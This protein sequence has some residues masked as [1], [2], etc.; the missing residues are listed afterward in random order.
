MR[1]S[2]I[3]ISVLSLSIFACSP[4]TPSVSERPSV[5]EQDVNLTGKVGSLR[6]V[7][8]SNS[9]GSSR[10]SELFTTTIGNVRVRGTGDRGRSFIEVGK[11]SILI[12]V[13]DYS[14]LADAVPVPYPHLRHIY[15]D[16]V[17]I[18]A[19]LERLP[20][21]LANASKEHRELANFLAMQNSVQ[22]QVDDVTGQQYCAEL[23]LLSSYLQELKVAV[24]QLPR[25]Q[26]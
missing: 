20:A 16:G 21:L 14:A 5:V 12:D 13:T 25:H 11:S 9:I 8:C 6:L 24:N 7:L 18:L 2:L 1:L 15:R 19:G 4:R 17:M 22:F 10:S 23:K 26:E 3:W